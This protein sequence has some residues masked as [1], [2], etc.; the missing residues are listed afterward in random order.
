MKIDDIQLILLEFD[1]LHLISC[2]ER[3]LCD[4]IC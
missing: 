2:D 3:Y 1:E 4:V